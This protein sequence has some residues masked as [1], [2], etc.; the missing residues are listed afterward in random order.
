MINRRLIRVKVFKVLFGRINSGSDS[1]SGAIGDLMNSCEK[2]LDLYFLLLSLPL[3]M[4]K[5]AE[6]KIELGLKKYQPTPEEALP[7]RRFIEN[8]IIEKLDSDDVF[9]KYCEKKGLN[10]NDYMPLV[11][12]LYNSLCSQDYFID[13]MSAPESSFE[14]DLNILI[15]FFEEELD[16]NDELGAILEDI[17][18]YWIDDME[19]VINVITKKLGY[20]KVKSKF[21][22]PDIFLK[23]DDR[24]YAV[25]LLETSLINYD[26]Y[27]EI[28]RGYIHNWDPERL[29]ATDTALIVLGISE[30]IAF[31]DIPVKVTI[32]E[33][34]E[35]S[36]FYSTP[37]S[38]VFVNGILDKIIAGL[39]AEGKIEK[40]GRGLVGSKE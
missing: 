7:N 13:Y 1:L 21:T 19:Y 38:K 26:K 29:A 2:T 35:L 11:K 23:D 40:K 16:E 10:W 39:M 15:R 37:N 4:K 27:V 14:G 31:H 25:K 28:M 9:L 30:A 22:H 5:V 20:L 8:R 6:S 24:E 32:N 34:V 17:S 12:K 36:K 3:A 18:L 33:Y